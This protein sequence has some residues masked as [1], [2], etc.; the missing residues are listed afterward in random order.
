[1]A[2]YMHDFKAKMANTGCVNSNITTTMQQSVQYKCV[3]SSVSYYI[4]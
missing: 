2:D 4:T 3:I 1:M